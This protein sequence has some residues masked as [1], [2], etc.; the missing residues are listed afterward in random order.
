VGG[1]APCIECGARAGVLLHG[2]AGAGFVTVA[3]AP[4]SP[5]SD[6]LPVAPGELWAATQ[7]GVTDFDGSNWTAPQMPFQISAFGAGSGAV[8]AVG[9]ASFYQNPSGSAWTQ[10]AGA[11]ASDGLSAVF[12]VGKSAAWAVGANGLVMHWDGNRWSEPSPPLVPTITLLS[13]V[14][15]SSADDI[16]LGNGALGEPQGP[17]A[18][19]HFDGSGFSPVALPQ[20]P[21]GLRVVGLCGSGANDVWLVAAL[22]V[23]NTITPVLDHFDGNTWSETTLPPEALALDGIYCPRAGEVWVV[24]SSASARPLALHGRGSG[25]A[26]TF[27]GSPLPGDLLGPAT[28]IWGNGSALFLGVVIADGVLPPRGVVLVGDGDTWQEESL[29][30]VLPTRLSGSGPDD[31][32]AAGDWNDGAPHLAHRDA[33]GWT[34][35]PLPFG[36]S[37]IDERSTPLEAIWAVSADEAYFAE[38]GS[39]WRWNGSTWSLDADLA[40]NEL[41]AIGGVAGSGDGIFAV[42][43]GGMIL[44]RADGVPRLSALRPDRQPGEQR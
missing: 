2:S 18:L 41:Q 35:V 13:A 4:P 11:T 29:P 32:W 24:G 17:A 7:A 19:Y 9:G 40:L 33:S 22:Y 15:A 21:A 16:Y 25:A 30:G 37:P 39:I 12:V 20:S 42:G 34:S 10:L 8:W 6:L 14:W 36:A 23:T 43:A 5:V 38:G 44:R 31:L 3:P 1:G 27:T 26:M 28:A